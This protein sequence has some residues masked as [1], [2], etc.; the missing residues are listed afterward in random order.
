MAFIP[1]ALAAVGTAVGAS[2]ATATAVGA[3]V[4]STAVST[5]G[6]GASALASSNA[7]K[8]QA[9]LAE[10]QA[11][12]ASEQ[13]SV[14]AGEVARD[15]RQRLAA[16]RA[17]ALQNGFELSGSMNDLLDQ[18]GRQ[19]QLDYL[20]AVYDGSVQATGLNAT[21]KNYRNQASNALIG[22]ALGAASSAL[23]GIG[24]VY[25]MRGSSI[26]VSGT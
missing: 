4:A 25:K 15:T 3:A 7:A 11:K 20:T 18:T 21:A 17:G 9:G 13:A 16:G 26:N 12:Q 14:K 10:M 1:A 6:V 2:A 19:G 8:F 22:G 5:L 23:G 24:S